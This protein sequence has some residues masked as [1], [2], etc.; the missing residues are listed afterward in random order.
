[1]HYPPCQNASVFAFCGL[2]MLA[3]AT[4]AVA[5]TPAEM[6]ELSLQE[7][8]NMQ[9]DE[10]SLAKGDQRT[11]RSPWS[12]G[13]SYHQTRFE[14]YQ[15]GTRELS[16]SEVLFTGAPGTRTNRNFPV[17][18]TTIQQEALIVTLSYAIDRRSSLDI[19][20]PYIKQSTDHISSVPG[21]ETFVLTSQGL[22]DV[23][24]SYSRAL[25]SWQNSSL[26]G[27]LGISAP[28]GSI[29]EKGDTPRSP[30]D[31]QL[32][33]TM[34]LGSGTWDIPFGLN[35]QQQDEHWLWGTQIHG[36]LRLG[37]ND[38]DYRL[39]D[40]FVLAPWIKLQR[41]KWLQ[42]MARLSFQYWDDIDGQDDELLVPGPFPFP[43]NITDPNNYGG[44]KINA[45]IGLSVGGPHSPLQGHK[46]DIEFG[47]PLYQ[48]LNGIQNKEDLNLSISWS[49]T[50]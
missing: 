40:R 14:G 18:P 20:I 36:K 23:S 26:S 35:Y 41:H 8:L 43:A 28:T 10:Q 1:M 25:K 47:K 33:Y 17:L 32:P 2:L 21:Y 27:T 49:K 38:R 19:G 39:G 7:L 31:Q 30:G 50:L 3:S 12:A 34:Q 45:G 4:R 48:D 15:T 6:A 24:I 13:L 11:S 22:G 9:I 37:R 5:N 46:I 16:N 42:P 44:K 29:D